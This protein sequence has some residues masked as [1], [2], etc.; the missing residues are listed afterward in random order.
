[1]QLVVS[2]AELATALAV[3]KRAVPSRPSH[4]ILTTVLIEAPKGDSSVTLT[5]F[6]MSIGIR[7][8]IPANINQP[9]SIACPHSILAEIVQKLP[10]DGP[11]T[12]DAK[13]SDKL[14]IHTTTGNYTISIKDPEDYPDFPKVD[15]TAITIPHAYI[16][17]ALKGVSY[18]VS[19]A[20]DKQL[21]QGVYFSIQADKFECAA[22]DGHRL[23]VLSISD[24][25]GSISNSAGIQ[26]VIPGHSLKEIG[27]LIKEQPEDILF[28]Y[29]KGQAVFQVGSQVLTTRLLEGT[30][31][32][33]RK[34]I[35]ASFKTDA[36]MNR[37]ALVASLERVAVL[38]SAHNNVVKITLDDTGRAEIAADAQDVG[39]GSEQVAAQV[40]GDPLT[41]AFNVA[42]LLDALKAFGSEQVVLSCNAP[43][44]PAI[45]RPV[46]DV[47]ERTALIM[48]VQIRS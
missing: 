24:D 4:P 13:N 41:A 15:A 23:S 27:G 35:P 17:Q 28:A 18:A 25:S 45:L 46:G 9:G 38:A 7:T 21:L 37:L 42:Y 47:G 30:Y 1:M 26:V 5:G 36:I 2:Q 16:S 32:D 34:L 48:P 8:S 20:A 14:E 11:I 31:P 43:T 40:E 6:D 3:V 22:T 39:S 44:T 12:L 10:K 19:D 33:Y 29:D